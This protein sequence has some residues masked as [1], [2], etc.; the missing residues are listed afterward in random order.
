MK[1][2]KNIKIVTYIIIKFRKKHILTRFIDSESLIFAVNSRNYSH[3]RLSLSRKA[4]VSED[5]FVIDDLKIHR[6]FVDEHHKQ[7]V[8]GTS[9]I[10]DVKIGRSDEKKPQTVGK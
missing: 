1:P 8:S 6:W 10:G 9:K 3:D 5:Y 7:N 4:H 2:D